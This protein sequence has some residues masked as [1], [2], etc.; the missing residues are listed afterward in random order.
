MYFWTTD[1]AHV[2]QVPEAQN[3]SPIVVVR[4]TSVVVADEIAVVSQ[5]S[6]QQRPFERKVLEKSVKFTGL[7]YFES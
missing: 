7:L 4:V 3:V 1:A 6:S 5:F 2:L